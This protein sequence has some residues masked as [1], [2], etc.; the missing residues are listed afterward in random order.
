MSPL[1][2]LKEGEHGEVVEISKNRNCGINHQQKNACKGYGRIT[3]LG[4]R[5]GKTI[6]VLQNRKRGALLVKVDESRIAIGRGMAERI[7]IKIPQKKAK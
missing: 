7:K 6:E 1:Y 5:V 2:E 4:I 3:D